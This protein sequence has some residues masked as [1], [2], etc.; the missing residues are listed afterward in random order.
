MRS[1]AVV[2]LAAI[3]SV[4]LAFPDGAGVCTNSAQDRSDVYDQMG[5]L[6]NVGNS[7]PFT[8]STMP[9]NWYMNPN[10]D[11]DDSGADVEV[12]I[13]GGQSNF[14]GFLLYAT[15]GSGN[16]QGQWLTTATQ[17]VNGNLPATC[18]AMGHTLTHR[19][20]TA[21]G[22]SAGEFVATWRPPLSTLGNSAIQFHA[23]LMVGG[24]PRNLYTLDATPISY[25]VTAPYPISNVIATPRWKGISVAFPRPATGGATITSYEARAIPRGG[26]S[27]ITVTSTV[28]PIIFDTLTN[29]VTYNITARARNSVGW[30]S[31]YSAVTAQSMATPGCFCYGH[32]STCD[33]NGNCQNCQGN[34]Q[35]TLC[36]VCTP[37]YRGDPT[38]GDC[39]I[40][41]NPSSAYAGPAATLALLVALV[42]AL[43]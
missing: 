18:K 41:S 17:T 39:G 4:A 3:L 1:Q 9:V 40:P 19:D 31:N 14:N 42:A 5:T 30:S 2:L 24:T 26:G 6:N 36:D 23:L 20:I 28:S 22:G 21:K 8:L 33:T 34:T 7:G 11:T 15:D 32:S 25:G 43:L 27:P 16:K 10:P 13:S 38:I 29:G 12:R 35:G 37:P